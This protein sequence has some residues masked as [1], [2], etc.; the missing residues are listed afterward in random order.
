MK[1]PFDD[2][3]TS[4]RH[5]KRSLLELN[6]NLNDGTKFTRSRAEIDLLKWYYKHSLHSSPKIALV[7]HN[8][9]R[10]RFLSGEIT[11]IFYS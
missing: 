1:T 11:Y 8:L 4:V 7:I 6:L 9:L 10:N 5:L 2:Q 3:K